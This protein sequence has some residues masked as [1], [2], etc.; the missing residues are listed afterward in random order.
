LFFGFL[1]DTQQGDCYARV[2]AAAGGCA[3]PLAARLSKKDC[4]CGKDVGVA[5]GNACETCPARGTGECGERAKTNARAKTKDRVAAEYVT[6]CLGGAANRT[7]PN[8]VDEC[9]LRPEMCGAGG[10]CVDT[11]DGYACEC[12]AGFTKGRHEESQVCE[13]Q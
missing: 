4:C 9:G 7:A 2:G 8:L 6:L 10:R 11:A 5:W 12:R 13:G 1:P 3:A